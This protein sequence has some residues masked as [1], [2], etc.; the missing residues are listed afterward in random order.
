M[1]CYYDQAFIVARDPRA[2]AA[3]R[4]SSLPVAHARLGYRGY[5][6]EISPDGAQPL[7]YDYDYVDPAPLASFKGRLTRHGDVTALLR[8]DDDQLCLVGPG[9]EV[10]IEF[11]AT[12]LPP[13]PAG[14][15]RSF[16]VRGI[17]Y[18]KDA[19]PFTATS[20]SIEPLPWRAMPPFPFRSEVTRPDQPAHDAYLRQFQTRPAGAGG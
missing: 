7:I 10:Q 8:A 3:L 19:D 18:C 4:V 6:R 12:N 2:L 5:T 17:G 15:A 20:D 13:L 9:D 16:V 1:E 14:W 11:P